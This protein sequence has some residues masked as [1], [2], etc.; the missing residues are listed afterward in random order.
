MVVASP[1]TS[2]VNVP[3]E[4]SA[5]YYP[6]SVS[7]AAGEIKTSALSST[8][9][10]TVASSPSAVAPVQYTGAAAAVRFSAS[11]FMVVAAGVF[12]S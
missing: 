4:S 11:M 10:G 3:A 2:A 5:P 6:A 7:S 8:A 1:E 9:I 12:V